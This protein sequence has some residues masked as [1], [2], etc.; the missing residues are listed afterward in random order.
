MLKFTA[1]KFLLVFPM[2][3]TGAPE[4]MNKSKTGKMNTQT[5][6]NVARSAYQKPYL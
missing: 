3:S 4:K 1:Q 5:N 2:W 6:T